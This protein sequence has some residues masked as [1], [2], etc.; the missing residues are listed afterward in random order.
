MAQLPKIL[1]IG[2]GRLAAFPLA[3]RGEE[4]GL[5]VGW[6]EWAGLPGL[7]IARVK[8]KMDTGARTSAL[9]ANSIDLFEVNGR[10]WV[11]FDVTG[12]AE[13]APWHEAAV[14]DRRS[15]RSSNG[16]AE[17]RFVIR[18]DLLLAGRLWQVEITLTNRESMDLP[19]LIGREALAGRV[20]VDPQKSWVWGKPTWQALKP[21]RASKGA[22]AAVRLGEPQ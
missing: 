13:N 5:V 10:P 1:L 6:R 15:V 3:P 20:L 22:K 18:T 12:E 14:A 11:R 17:L 2:D 19:M 8:A 9:H 16:G 4:A 7:G 21:R